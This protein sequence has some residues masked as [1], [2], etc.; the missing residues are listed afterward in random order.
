MRGDR[1]DEHRQQD[2]QDQSG[3]CPT[4]TKYAVALNGSAR[5]YAALR[6]GRGLWLCWAVVIVQGL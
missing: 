6:L 3:A 2:Y 4:T 1:P 5:A